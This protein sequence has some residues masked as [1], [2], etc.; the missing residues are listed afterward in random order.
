M[1]RVLERIRVPDA[2]IETVGRLY[3]A[4]AALGRRLR[5]R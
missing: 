5:R 3:K 4:L 2:A 1:I